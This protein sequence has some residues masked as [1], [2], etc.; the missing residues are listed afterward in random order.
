MASRKKDNLIPA[1]RKSK[2]LPTHIEPITVNVNLNVGGTLTLSMVPAPL[3]PPPLK[4]VFTVTFE[5]FQVKGDAPMAYT[6]PVDKMVVVAVQYADTGGN[7]VDLPQGNV[8]WETSESTILNVQ[9]DASDDQQ[10]SLTPAG[11]VGNAQVTCTG[12]N[13]DGSQVIATLDITVVAGDAVSGTIQPTGEP[14]PIEP[15]AE[16]HA[17][18]KHR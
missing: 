18:S 6:L 3:P 8:H 17:R 9:P 5:G 12:S 2:P 11:A 14:Q 4:A 16:Q 10:C 7:V 13:P 15:H 1:Y